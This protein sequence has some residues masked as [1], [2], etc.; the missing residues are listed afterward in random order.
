MAFQLNFEALM[1]RTP[2]EREADRAAVY[3][4]FE[5]NL[6]QKIAVRRA[7]IT[8]LEKVAGLG[9]WETGFL[10]SMGHLATTYDIG[11]ILGEKLASLTD[12][13][14]ESLNGMY[15]K[16]CGDDMA[17][18]PDEVAATLGALG[19]DPT[20]ARVSEVL[21]RID[22]NA[23]RRDVDRALAVREAI[24]AAWRDS[25]ATRGADDPSGEVAAREESVFSWA[26]FA[27]AGAQSYELSTA[28]DRRFSALHARLQDGRTI[29]EAYQLDVKGYR[30]FGD[31]WRLGKGKAPL[32]AMSHDDVWVAYKG[33]WKEWAAENP[34]LMSE[35]RSAAS[36]KVLTDRF[37]STQVSQARAL[38][39]ILSGDRVERISDLS[40]SAITE[41]DTQT[42]F[43]L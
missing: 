37:A 41:A 11:A 39:E 1:S 27:P 13:Q 15:R 32:V 29:E 14:L 20:A 4:S 19:E 33:L 6:K 25:A 16:H 3:T 36:G 12:K 34:T 7:Q 18:T 8:A 42:S 31:D 22:G 17:I 38:A 24:D 28:G 21:E 43:D 9:E 30:E 5:N 35:L 40:L 23:M 26:R 2:D 10:R